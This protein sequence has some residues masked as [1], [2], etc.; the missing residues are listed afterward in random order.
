MVDKAMSA[1]PLNVLWLIDHVCFDG[2]LHAG[3]RLYMNV[4]PR[5]DPSKVQIHPYFMNAS[6]AVVRAFKDAKHPVINLALSK[7]DVFSPLKVGALA[8][9]HNVDVMHLFCFGAS[10]F[11]RV[12]SIWNRVPSVIHE[13][14]TPT[15]GPYPTAFKV[16]DRLLV[17]RTSYALGAS[18]HCRDF[19]HEQRF[20]PRDKIEVLYHA[21]PPEK[22]E[23]AK[24]LTRDAARQELGWNDGR[25][26]Y[27]T[28]TKLGPDR[29]NE[30]LLEAFSEVRKQV[31]NAHLCIVYRPTLYHK[32]PVKYQHIPWVTDPVA[33]RKR[34]EELIQQ[35]GLS[36]CVSLV[37]MEAPERH[38]PYFAASDVVVAPFES[39][40]FSSVNLIEAMVFGRPHVVT[41]LGEPA[42]IVNRWGAGIKVPPNNAVELAKGMTALAQNSTL[43]EGLI[44]KAYAAAIE[45]GVDAVA[46]RLS[47]LY[48]RIADARQ[49]GPARVRATG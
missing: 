34:I 24:N 29:G 14:D 28:V 37:E 38:E 10:T 36:D 19:I 11:G 1:Q 35:R 16:V 26:V 33:M 2:S 46:E 20:V 3:G 12:A 40:L 5:I 30:T 32:V 4:I 47:R 13:F 18:T 43:R 6:E 42:D 27:L 39:P 23:T 41:D 8:R 44:Q 9:R 7:Y 15:Y 45:F 21:V 22:F 25:F 49:I 17:G 48:E 31:P